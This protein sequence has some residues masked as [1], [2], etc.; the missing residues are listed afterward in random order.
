PCDW[1]DRAHFFG[2]AA[3]VMRHILI[4]YARTRL[5]GKR[6]GGHMPIPF[7]EALICSDDRLEQLISL[8]EALDKLE[9]DDPRAVRVVVLRFYSGMSLEEI[10]E[11]LQLSSRTVKR[12]WS[13]ARAWLRNELGA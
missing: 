8:D 13:Y 4:D 2:V 10:G 5:A 1:K 11:F 9:Q 12:D 7:D 6:G 3:Q